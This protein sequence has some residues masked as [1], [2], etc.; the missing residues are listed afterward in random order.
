YNY[1]Q[2]AAHMKR[3]SNTIYRWVSE[4]MD[5]LVKESAEKVL[6]LELARWTICRAAS[7]KRPTTVT[8][9]P[10]SA[11][12]CS[13][14]TRRTPACCSSGRQRRANRTEHCRE[15]SCCRRR[16]RKPGRRSTCS[17]PARSTTPSQDCRHCQSDAVARLAGS[18]NSRRTR[19]LDEVRA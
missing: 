8:S 18:R 9:P 16:S 6:K 4:A 14:C 7:T 11:A 19:L 13:G 1:E 5:R 15:V 12:G 17:R 10:Y 3:P 2:I